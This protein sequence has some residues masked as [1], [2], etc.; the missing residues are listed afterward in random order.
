MPGRSRAQV[1]TLAPVAVAAAVGLGVTLAVTFA[2]DLRFAYRSPATHLAL[3]NV[4]ASVAVL[5]AVLLYGRYR[6]ST[7]RRDLLVSLAFALLAGCG[8]LLVVLPAVTSRPEPVWTSWIPLVVRLLAAALVALAA[9]EQSRTVSNPSRVRHAVVGA[10]AVLLALVAVGLV[11]G[12]RLPA[13][14]DPGLS[15]GQSHRPALVGDAAV[16][17]AQAIHALLYG[18]AAVA[19]AVHAT[20][21]KDVLTRWLAA[22]C[23]LAAFAR[24][25]YFLFPS[26]YSP[27]VYTGDFLRT[28]FY[29][30]LG[31]G[32]LQELRVY[33]T[34]HAEAAVFA[35]RRRLARDLHDGTV[36]ELGYIR[37]LA[38]QAARHPADATTVE[39]IAAAADRALAEARQA[40][41][42]LSLPLDEPLSAVIERTAGEIADRYD[43]DVRVATDGVLDVDRPQ[44]EAIVRIVRE[45][46]SNAAR[47]AQ[48]RHIAVQLERGCVEIRDDGRGFDPH[49]GPDG[50]YGLVSMRE[51]AEAVGGTLQVSSRSGSGTTVRMVWDA[52]RS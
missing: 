6:R 35:E 48:A 30:V 2:P 5:V 36:Q 13:P 27:W 31:Y 12:D 38:R 15:P 43:I 26:L 16:L 32:A 4:D 17:A 25:N 11:L 10:A 8:Y 46:V 3:E 50:G 47:H 1:A 37:T 28:A 21:T 44:R 22:G 14:I 39:R 23:A 40:I 19:F 51:R 20:R 9:V 45:A 7:V 29:L 42:A 18:C 41:D 34:L 49:A 33:W 52:G 24:V